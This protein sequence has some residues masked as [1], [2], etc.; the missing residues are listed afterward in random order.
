MNNLAMA[1]RGVWVIINVKPPPTYWTNV[2]HTYKEVTGAWEL[3]LYGRRH[4]QGVLVTSSGASPGKVRGGGHL[5][6]G[7]DHDSLQGG[8]QAD[9]S[10]AG[11]VTGLYV[12]DRVLQPW[13]IQDQAVCNLN[14]FDAVLKWE[15]NTWEYN[16][17]AKIDT[18]P[19]ED[20]C[21]I[22]ATS[23]VLVSDPL[24]FDKAT[25]LCLSLSSSVVVPSGTSQ[26]AAILNLSSGES[27]CMGK[28]DNLIWL[29]VTDENSESLWHSKATGDAITYSNWKTGSPNGGNIENCAVLLSGEFAGFW[30]DLSCTVNYNYCFVC[31]SAGPVTLTLR[32]LCPL[33]PYDSHYVIYGY[34]RSRPF[35]RGYTGTNLTWDGKEW[36]LEH[37]NR[38]AKSSLI[39]P[40]SMNFPVGRREWVVSGG[41]CTDAQNTTQLT[42]TLTTC[43]S[44]QFTCG[45]GTCLPMAQRCNFQTDCHD[46]TDEEN[47]RTVVFPPSYKKNIPPPH[48][49]GPLPVQIQI[50]VLALDINTVDMQLTLDMLVRLQ[51]ADPRLL[52]HNLKVDNVLNTLTL[53]DLLRLWSPQVTTSQLVHLWSSQV[54]TGQLAHLLSSQVTTV[55]IYEGKENPVQLRRKYSVR[56]VCNFDLSMYPFDKQ[57]CHLVFTLTSAPRQYL[58][59]RQLHEQGVAFLGSKELIEYTIEKV[60][61]ATSNS[62][63]DLYSVQMVTI[64]FRRRYGYYV[65]TTYIPSIFFVCIAYLTTYFK[66]SNFQVRAI[67]SLTSM[68]VLTTLFSQTSSQLPRTSYFKMIDIWMFGA[69]GCIFSIIVTQT[70]VDFIHEPNEPQK[71]VPIKVQEGGMRVTKESSTKQSG[72]WRPR[73]QVSRAATLMYWA[74]VIFP[75]LLSIFIFSYVTFIAAQG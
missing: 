8:Y 54:T 34:K 42:L 33:L 50:S 3:Y 25:R 6:L 5:I 17:S 12:W 20:V 23:H 57:E 55:D 10:Y 39:P 40:A 9:Q 44:Q 18:A 51:W 58:T 49:P 31:Q 43:N 24:N 72:G 68:L 45:D 46:E 63:D 37:P 29:G 26:N 67:V 27:R 22:N 2:C 48:S 53:Q 70:V 61:M 14:T 62:S 21:T 15:P 59:L 30:A 65:L 36:L 19:R 16:N 32:G 69:I 13:E 47:C 56:Y 74:R 35:F 71:V 66:L 75:I 41:G 4:S 1:V 7:Q 38:A 28:G 11:Q 64:G 52:Y 73:G 60:T